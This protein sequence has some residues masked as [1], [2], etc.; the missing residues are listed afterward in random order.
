MINKLQYDLLREDWGD[1]INQRCVM[2]CPPLQ[3]HP[4]TE[5]IYIKYTYFAATS[6]RFL[7]SPQTVRNN[8]KCIDGLNMRG[9]A[10]DN[11]AYLCH[12]KKQPFDHDAFERYLDQYAAFADWVVLPDVVCDKDQTLALADR[13]IDKI[14]AKH[15]GIKMLIVWQDGMNKVDLLRFV[16]NG[17]G[18]F[19]GGST[20]GKLQNMKWIA[21]M[22][23]EFD[24][25]CHVGRVNTLQRLNYVLKCGANSFD[26]SGIVRFLPTL[27]LLACRL[28]QERDQLSLFQK[29]TMTNEFLNTWL[30]K[31]RAL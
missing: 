14:Q 19:V 21:D 8:Q 26:G 23:K 5:S 17:V 6:L 11:G 1:Y 27:R 7:C 24:V 9:Y 22:C 30:Q 10:L 29:D 12:T 4:N 13:Y 3:Y 25:W 2:Y 28:I 18:V 31:K 15:Q 16:C 20:E